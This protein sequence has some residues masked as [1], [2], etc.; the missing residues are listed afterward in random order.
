MF[1]SWQMALV[2]G[3]PSARLYAIAALGVVAGHVVLALR[4]GGG[5]AIGVF[6]ADGT[7]GLCNLEDH[8][9]PH[10]WEN[11]QK[12]RALGENRT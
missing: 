8:V 2:V 3:P 11:G 10:V 9:D 7:A 12:K 5:G 4:K 1:F 6:C